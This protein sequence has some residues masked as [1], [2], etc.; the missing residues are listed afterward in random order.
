MAK[1]KKTQKHDTREGWLRAGMV[2]LKTVL[3]DAT[4]SMD[5]G[6]RTFDPDKVQVSV[7]YAKGKPKAIG[8]CFGPN[9]TGN[10]THSVFVCPSLEVPSR[11]LDILLHELIHA[12]VGVG[13]G[14]KKPFSSVAKK[15]GLSG[16]PTATF[17]A[18]DSELLK[19]LEAIASKLGDY[20][21]AKMSGG[22]GPKRPPAGGWIKFYSERADDYILRVSPKALLEYGPPQDP[23]GEEMTLEVAAWMG[24]D[25]L[26]ACA[27]DTIQRAIAAYTEE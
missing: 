6:A 22:A 20:P 26:K 14:H 18:E 12:A 21:H 4:A 25:I 2:E 8:Q 15:V 9:W 13:H 7:G 11:V 24:P 16:K 10:D 27:G 1:S 19:K 3:E 5:G 23:W 17:A